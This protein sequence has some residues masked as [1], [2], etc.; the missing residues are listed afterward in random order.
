[1]FNVC[2]AL[3]VS[4]K[5]M[6]GYIHRVYRDIPLEVIYK[7]MPTFEQIHVH[8]IPKCIS[9]AT[10]FGYKSIKRKEPKTCFSSLHLV[11]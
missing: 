9:E 2:M 1:M 8:L 5:P 3:A 10:M 6:R 11:C 4:L 7:N